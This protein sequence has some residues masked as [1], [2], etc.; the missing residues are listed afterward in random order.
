[1]AEAVQ[2]ANGDRAAIT[3][4]KTAFKAAMAEAKQAYETALADLGPR[5]VVAK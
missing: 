5:P 2:A 3:A 1:M 4:A